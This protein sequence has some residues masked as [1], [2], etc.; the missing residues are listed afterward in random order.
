MALNRINA[1]SEQIL[2]CAN[3][4]CKN[5][6]YLLLYGSSV[7]SSRGRDI[8]ALLVANDVTPRFVK[9][10]HFS[11]TLN[12]HI[13]TPQIITSDIMLDKFGWIFLT[14]LLGQFEV[15]AG[16]STEADTNKTS[17]YL[18]LAGQW[19][20]SMPAPQDFDFA[21]IYD[22]IIATLKMWNPQFSAYLSA[23]RIDIDHYR[24][25]TLNILPDHTLTQK[26]F[27]CTSGRYKLRTGSRY[28]RSADL[29]VVLMRYW[30][31]YV[32]Y[33]TNPD[34]YLTNKV[35]ELLR[36]KSVIYEK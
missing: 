11:K 22:G 7:T 9:R 34:F 10:P 2:A 23:G 4:S 20:G 36:K 13:V 29:R 27:I 8:D 33:Q 35:E 32:L 24:R 6:R 25:F 1:L 19:F 16:K 18:R 21:D 14:K 15:I 5:I 17:A 28:L 26:L 31:H 30:S 3:V 12:L